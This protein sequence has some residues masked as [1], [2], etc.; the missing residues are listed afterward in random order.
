MPHPNPLV[1]TS[2]CSSPVSSTTSDDPRSYLSGLLRQPLRQVLAEFREARIDTPVLSYLL[3]QPG[4]GAADEL[5]ALCEFASRPGSA[6]QTDVKKLRSAMISL[7]VLPTPSRTLDQLRDTG[8]FRNVPPH[9]WPNRDNL[10]LLTSDEGLLLWLKYGANADGYQRLFVDYVSELLRS[11]TMNEAPAMDIGP[12]LRVLVAVGR[13]I[14]NDVPDPFDATRSLAPL[15][16]LCAIHA[17]DWLP[18][19]LDISTCVNQRDL[20]GYPLLYPALAATT[21]ASRRLG[22]TPHEMNRALQERIALFVEHDA[23]LT[24]A[25]LKGTPLTVQ[26]VHDGHVDAARVLLQFGANPSSTDAGMNSVLH[27]LAKALQPLSSQSS[28][29]V[30]AFI[31]ALA[32]GGDPHR[33]NTGGETAIDLLPRSQREHFRFI[34]SHYARWTHFDAH[35]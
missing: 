26:L 32:A 10:D 6:Y 34:A 28:A 16:H 12:A 25:D 4:C 33:P 8:M 13:D 31:A 24:V 23:N 7:F 29:T 30:V 27:H 22:L 20:R 9:N 17:P 11:Q 3:W 1:P 2:Q 15:S 21:R 14:A 5:R 35:P 18:F 19:L